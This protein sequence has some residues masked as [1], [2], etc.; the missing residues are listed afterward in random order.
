MSKYEILLFDADATLLDFKRSER[1]A[2][3]ESLISFDL[4]AT[5]E[6]IEKY[7]STFLTL[8][9]GAR[10]ISKRVTRGPEM[11]PVTFPGMLKSSSVLW[12]ISL[13]RS[14]AWLFSPL[15]S[16]PCASILT[17]GRTKSREGAADTLSPCA[18]GRVLTLGG[19]GAV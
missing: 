5:D 14:M 2:V 15:T 13:E 10:V 16:L 4:P 17:G 7:S 12:S 6:I 11:Y 1:E 18:A 19:S 3:I 8:T 9:P